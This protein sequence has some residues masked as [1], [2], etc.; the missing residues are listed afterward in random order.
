V[1][2]IVR[3]QEMSELLKESDVLRDSV[4]RNVHDTLSHMN[5]L[6]DGLRSW[7]KNRAAALKNSLANDMGKHHH[8][9]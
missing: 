3:V 2:D 9:A 5:E 8:H 4:S 1:F 6:L 7:Q